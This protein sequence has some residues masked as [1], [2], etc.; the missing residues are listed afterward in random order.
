MQKEL[1]EIQRQRLLDMQAEIK[2]SQEVGNLEGQT[3]SPEVRSLV[4]ESKQ[5]EAQANVQAIQGVYYETVD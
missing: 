3:L 2:F 5:N 1:D 4:Q